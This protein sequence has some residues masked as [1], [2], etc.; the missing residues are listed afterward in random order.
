ME[1]FNQ[2]KSVRDYL[3]SKRIENLSVGLVPTMGALH[4]GHLSLIKASNQQNDITVCSIYVNPTQFN[5]P[6]DL[7]KY[8][9]LLAK[10]SK[11]LLD[12]GCHVL[13]APDNGQMYAQPS[14]LKFDFGQLDSILEG[15]FRPGHFSGVG[16]VVSKLFNIIQP[17]RAYFGQKDFQ[18]F[19]VIS[20][21]TEELLFDIELKS[22]PIMREADGL[23]MSSRNLR[24]NEEER[25]K[26]LIFYQSL[27]TAKKFLSEGKTWTQIET[28]IN[29]KFE[30]SSGVTLEYVSLADSKNLKPIENVNTAKHPIILI[31][32]Y[33]GDVRLIDNLLLHE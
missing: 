9:R 1:V 25:K 30:S 11:M 14:E 28:E 21:L 12:C 7:A 27:L 22:V 32:G 13:F 15:K 5:N 10:D 23:A 26:A 6:G 20:K 4:A 16:L 31:A 3:K 8:P 2:I 33:V 19:A 29:K 24:L 18:Q 17:T